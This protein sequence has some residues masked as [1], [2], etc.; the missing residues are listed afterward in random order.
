M[1]R[2]VWMSAVALSTATLAISPA[3]AQDLSP[4][5]TRA[6][7]IQDVVLFRSKPY[8]AASTKEDHFE[9]FLQL[10]PNQEKLPLTLI[11]RNGADGKVPFNWFRVNIN[12]YLVASEKD[13]Q[14][15]R[16]AGIDLT[17]R[18]QPG[19]A[20]VLIDAAGEPG[21][22]LTLQLST[23]PVV[24]TQVEPTEIE[25]GSRVV[26]TGQNFS[27]DETQD[28]VYIGGKPARI[29][30]A[31]STSITAQ[32]PADV[33]PGR[34][35]VQVAVDGIPSRPLGAIV[36]S[37]PAPVL[38]GTNYW[39]AP[40]GAYLTING[41]NFGDDPSKIQVMFKN[42]SA[43]VIN[44]S[45][46]SLTV[47]VPNWSYGG[48]ELNIPLYVIANGVRSANVLP[49]D[50]GP[51]YLGAIPPIPG[52][53]YSEAG[54]EA[55]SQAITKSGSEATMGP[56]VSP[57]ANFGSSGSEASGGHFPPIYP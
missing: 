52:D 35:A 26:V 33:A 30:S 41:R 42:V 3:T 53:S 1:K 48:N 5:A 50:I 57:N 31:G 2:L 9:D 13:M 36:S 27:S 47:M 45:P 32:V 34:T 17:G 23:P 54:S 15:K 56:I 25:P 6:A 12:G 49:F 28:A 55:G 38:T 51:K 37:V 10:Q 20:Q 29:L 14:G 22:T 21:A 18:M 7:E 24:V 43:Q 44:A 4:Q 46:N 19:S 16:E 40:P 11:V 39:M 8:V